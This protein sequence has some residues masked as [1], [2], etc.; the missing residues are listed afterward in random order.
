M[1]LTSLIV[2]WC[3]ITAGDGGKR[4]RAK[5]QPCRYIYDMECG[6]SHVSCQKKG[7]MLEKERWHNQRRVTK[8]GNFDAYIIIQCDFLKDINVRINVMK[9]E[10]GNHV[11]WSHNF[12]SCLSNLQLPSFIGCT[13]S[14][15]PNYVHIHWEWLGLLI[16]SGWGIKKYYTCFG[17]THNQ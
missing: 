12:N 10:K 13:P 15:E 14:G 1:D 6:K 3:W 16:Q 4:Q 7:N 9:I 5:P 8:Y 2:C 17:F 11:T